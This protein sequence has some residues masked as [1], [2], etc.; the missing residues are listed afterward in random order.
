M[1]EQ[2]AENW[3]QALQSYLRAAELDRQNATV[4]YRLGAVYKRL[5]NLEKSR[6]ELAEFQRLKAIEKAGP[7]VAP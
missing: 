4:H 6:A 3:K 2:T 5:G 1:L 7:K